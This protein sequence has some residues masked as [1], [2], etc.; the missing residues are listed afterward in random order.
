MQLECMRVEL[1]A[2]SLYGLTLI[3]MHVRA[4]FL[5]HISMKATAKAAIFARPNSY[6]L[7]T[8]SNIKR[9]L[10]W[11]KILFRYWC[12]LCYESITGGCKE[13][14]SV[15]VDIKVQANPF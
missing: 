8:V 11:I 4:C 9:T 15:K 12:D 2:P 7:P 3:T 10:A 14:V 5:V 1:A 6:S 13:Y